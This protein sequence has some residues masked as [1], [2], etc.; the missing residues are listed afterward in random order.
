MFPNRERFPTARMMVEM[1]ILDAYAKSQGK[2]VKDLLGVSKGVVSV[3]YG[4]SLG[5]GD[6]AGIVAQATEAL[7][8]G[9]SKIKLKVSPTSYNHVVSA[10]QKLHSMKGFE[11]MVDANGSFDPEND[12]RLN[13]LR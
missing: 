9:A 6:V 5:E 8:N 3:P 1:A 11:I 12:D 10:I 2:S 7:N 13:M 4:K